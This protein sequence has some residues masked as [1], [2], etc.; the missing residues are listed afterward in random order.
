MLKKIIVA[1][2]LLSASLPS[3]A[4]TPHLPAPLFNNLGSFHHSISTNSP[5]AQ[6]YFD[7]GM[8]LFYGFEWGESIRS[9]R[10][11]INQDPNCAL[12]YWGLALSLGY[13]ANA[14]MAGNEY[15]Q[16][17][18]A[19]QK[20]LALASKATPEEQA[21]ILALRE[22]FQHTPK[23]VTQTGTFSCHTTG[24]DLDASSKNEVLNY[25]AAMKKVSQS[26]P[27]DNDAK[28]LYAYSLFDVNEW[29]FWGLEGKIEKNTETLVQTLESILANNKKHA[30]ANH[31]F[32]H[33][34]EQSP[35]PADAMDSA[36]R[37]KTLVPGSEHLV[38]M[39]AHIYFLTGLYH[40]ATL[41]NLQ[42]IK[43]YKKYS[44]LCLKQGFK[45]EVTYMNQHNFYFLQ[46]TAAMEGHRK[47]ALNAAK[48]LMKTLPLPMI[49]NDPYLQWFIPVPYY[50]EARF[51]LWSDILKE[52]KPQ[53]PYHY[54]Q[55]MWHYAR[56]MAY[57]HTQHLKEAEEESIQLNEL[58]QQGETPENLSENGL[59][60]LK[61]AHEILLGTLANFH[62]IEKDT[63][64]H[65]KTA[66]QM[67]INMGYHE[68]PDWYFPVKEIVAD[69]YLKWGHPLE[70]IQ[71]YQQDLK[72][73]PNNGW[74]LFGLY[75]SYESLGE[76]QKSLEA[77]R[78]FK[79]AWIHADIPEP[80]SLF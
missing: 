54:A 63:L 56:A 35:H 48:D 3:N 51:A 16:A 66:M 57:A 62:G 72:Q 1:L 47:L 39:P 37:L 44:K 53:D 64:S 10:G 26:F 80:V 60:L 45:P 29:R 8:T 28:A 41:A 5:L 73:Y 43:T 12:C 36:H 69:A 55:G 34:I 68:P 30:G 22:R 6:R 17:Q 18:L 59:K 40:K 46:S 11:A 74:A 7:Q 52:A 27:E 14:P 49:A 42:A 20:A 32:I 19:M 79:K 33:L 9:F 15:Q 23:P 21:Y 31:Y 75:K 78:Q 71:Y 65:L 58:I 2:S 24:S 50:I 70:A 67:Q 61:I 13:K 25:A 38:H 77:K 76:K 4:T